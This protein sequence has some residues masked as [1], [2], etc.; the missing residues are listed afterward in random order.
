MRKEKLSPSVW[1]KI[2]GVHDRG[3]RSFKDQFGSRELMNS[4]IYLPITGTIC[5]GRE[6]T[7]YDEWSIHCYRNVLCTKMH[8]IKRKNCG[9]SH[10]VCGFHNK[11]LLIMKWRN[12]DA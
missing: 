12:R 11:H 4:G 2:A 8:S 7:N 5:N 6:W 10:P 9:L 1:R 3:W